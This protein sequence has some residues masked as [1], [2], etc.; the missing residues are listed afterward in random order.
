MFREKKSMAQ[1]ATST[2][3]TPTTWRSIWKVH[4]C[5][6]VFPMMSDA[7]LDELAADIK[8]HGLRL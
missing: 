8:S 3:P 2:P 7:E 1:P 5:A 4:P 6:D